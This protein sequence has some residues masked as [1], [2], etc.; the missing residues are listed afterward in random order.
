MDHGCAPLD[1]LP[2]RVSFRII[3]LI[4]RSLTDLALEAYL[5]T[6]LIAP[7]R[8]SPLFN[9]QGVFIAPFART[10][11]K[12]NRYFSVIGPSLWGGLPLA[13]RLF[14]LVHSDSVCSPIKTVLFG[15]AGIG[16]APE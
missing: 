2:Q 15:R 3:S 10:T 1:I 13:L 8:R 6:T 9:E 4:W 11:T 16:S 7:G 5:R 14:H 12:Q